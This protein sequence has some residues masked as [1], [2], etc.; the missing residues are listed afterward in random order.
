MRLENNTNSIMQ[1]NASAFLKDHILDML[2][3]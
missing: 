1:M 2:Q 3:H